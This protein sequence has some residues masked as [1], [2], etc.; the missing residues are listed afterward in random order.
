MVM[1]RQG[2]TSKLVSVYRRTIDWRYP[3]VDEES[4]GNSVYRGYYDLCRQ[5]SALLAVLSTANDS[6]SLAIAENSTLIVPALIS[7]LKAK[8]RALNQVSFPL[9]LSSSPRWT[10]ISVD[11]SHCHG[12]DRLGNGENQFQ[13][14]VCSIRCSCDLFSPSLLPGR[15]TFHLLSISLTWF[16]RR[17]MASTW[18]VK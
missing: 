9:W 14:K 13:I 16:L 8:D 11:L 6:V 3:K 4:Y 5:F 12:C 15:L 17:A 2:G 18:L 7:S 1:D 10:V